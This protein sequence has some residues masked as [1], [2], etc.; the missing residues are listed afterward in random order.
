MI[1]RPFALT[2]LVGAFAAALLLAA[3]LRAQTPTT[4]DVAGWNALQTGNAQQAATL[5][6]EALRVNPRDAAS[7]FG[8]GAAA[9]MLGR[10]EDALASLQRALALD[11]RMTP[12]SDLLG[13]IQYEQGDIAEAIQTYE[14][15]LAGPTTGDTAA[16]QARLERW[17]K[18]AAVHSTLAE[19]DEARFAIT[20]NGRSD[21]TLASR[22][23]AILER[24]YWTIGQKLGAYPSSRILVTLYSDEQFRDITN[25]PAWSGGLFDGRIRIPVKG[26]AQDM[27]AFSHVLV[28]ELTHAMIHSVAARG[29]P[30]WLHE[31]L[32]SYFEPRDPAVAERRMRSL[33][34]TLPLASLEDSFGQLTAAQAAVAYA[35]SLCAADLLLHLADGRVSVVLQALGAGQSFD[36]SL[37][38]IGLGAADFE[39]QLTRRLRR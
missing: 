35:E 18:E 23:S 13:S 3:S 4:P 14:A 29:V 38:Q 28:H 30:A 1:L 9:H 36:T 16:M 12:A 5:F 19:R 11:P 27:D 8:A 25:A 6:A 31:G 20:F 21:P 2:G 7:L 39:A 37:R 26:A 22:A 10:D 33:G 24:A 34:V 15:A 17:R 32:A